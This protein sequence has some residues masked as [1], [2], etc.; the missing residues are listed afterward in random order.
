MLDLCQANKGVYIKVGQHIG[1]L[2]YLVPKEY[3]DTMKVL[4][5]HA[6][7]SALSEVYRVLEEDLKMNVTALG[8]LSLLPLNLTLPCIH[9]IIS[10][11]KRFLSDKYLPPGNYRKKRGRKC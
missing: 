4:H 7:T 8:T 3:V 5:S 9:F 1:A 11:P 2:D 6:P 10:S